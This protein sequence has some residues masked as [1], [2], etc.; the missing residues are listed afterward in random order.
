MRTKISK[1]MYSR[2]HYDYVTKA[3][4]KFMDAESA[5]DVICEV[6][7]LLSY[8]GED[9]NETVANKNPLSSFCFFPHP[10]E[11]SS[12]Q[13]INTFVPADDGSEGADAS[14]GQLDCVD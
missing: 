5:D 11:L 14:E 9:L 7:P 2:L 10:D 3:G 1:Y 13:E 8:A 4:G 12:A 6:S